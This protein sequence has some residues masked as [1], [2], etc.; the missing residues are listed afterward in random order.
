MNQ[1][2]NTTVSPIVP[3]SSF[4]QD[5]AHSIR[6]SRFV[7]LQPSYYASVLNDYGYFVKSIHSGR[8]R[9]EDRKAHQN[10][11]TTFQKETALTEVGDVFP[12]ITLKQSHLYG[13]DQAFF[14]IFRLWCKNGAAMRLSGSQSQRV[15]HTGDAKSQF[16]AAIAELVAQTDLVA[17]LVKSMSSRDVTP[18]QVAEF[19]REVARIRLG[20]SDSISNI[21]YQD[22]MRVHRSAD[23]GQDA[24][25]VFN[26]VQENIMR[27]GLRYVSSSLNEQGQTMTRNMTARPLG[28]A[29]INGL[30]QDVETSRTVDTNVSI[31]DAAQKILMGA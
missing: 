9:N 14:G 18:T 21:Q 20:E 2:Q 10:V 1:S 19:T 27:Y 26:V 5:K 25:T 31:W 29:R 12:R 15:R 23:A 4:T 30:T 7:P 16:E 22:L 6:S 28:T 13:A 17:D 24:F 3:V 11:I 8:A